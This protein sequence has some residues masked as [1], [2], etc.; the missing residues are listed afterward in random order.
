MEPKKER[1]LSEKACFVIDCLTSDDFCERLSELKYFNKTANIKSEDIIIMVDKLMVI[2]ELAHIGK[3]PIC[4]QS[5]D[6]S[7]KKLEEL[8]QHFC[9]E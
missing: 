6:D 1:T 5:H 9:K 2:Y 8:Y 4:L 7:I 3:N